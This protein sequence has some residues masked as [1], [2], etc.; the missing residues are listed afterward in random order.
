MKESSEASAKLDQ[1]PHG[2]S[3]I[4]KVGFV[5]SV[6]TYFEHLLSPSLELGVRWK[7]EKMQLLL[8]QSR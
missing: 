1:F 6:S 8:S 2:R 3:D 7:A 5:D 4:G